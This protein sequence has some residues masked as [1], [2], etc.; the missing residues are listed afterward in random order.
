[1]G[2][3]GKA[4]FSAL[5]AQ[6]GGKLPA[7]AQREFEGSIK[8]ARLEH[9]FLRVRCERCRRLRTER[10]LLLGDTRVGINTGFAVVGTFGGEARFDYTAHG[11]AVN[12]AA[13]LEGANKY[14]GTL[15]CVSADTRARCDGIAFR[16]IGK[17]ILEGKQE[18]VEVFEPLHPQEVSETKLADYLAAYDLMARQ[19]PRACDAFSVLAERTPEDGLIQL[20]VGR[21]RSGEMGDVFRLPGK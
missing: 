19:D 12:T 6:Q 16:P 14:L 4:S 18:A 11:D 9:G 5:M 10:G 13:R 3:E 7:Y 2:A 1:M 21:L 17:L 15:I 20:H 8:R